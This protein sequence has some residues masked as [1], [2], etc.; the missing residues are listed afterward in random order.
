M[1]CSLPG[2]SV[3]GVSQAKNTGVG[4]HFLLQGSP[5]PRD[6]ICVSCV[7]RW[8]L[9]QLCHQGSPAKLCSTATEPVPQSPCSASRDAS[10]VSPLTA[11]ERSPCSLL[12][13]KA[14]ARQWACW[15]HNT[16]TNLKINWLKRKI[17]SHSKSGRVGPC[18]FNTIREG[19]PAQT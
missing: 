12:P 11:E 18:G 15:L 2:S 4:C 17:F 3:H 16:V 6:G 14:W 5:R 10:A 13:E 8:V 19:S 1:D 9:C 7:G